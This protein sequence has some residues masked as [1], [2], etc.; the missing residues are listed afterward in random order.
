[1]RKNLWLLVVAA[2]LFIFA[3]CSDDKDDKDIAGEIAG[4][5]AGTITVTQED[6][7]K[8]GDPMENQKIY[9]TRKGNN[10]VDLELKD[11]QF[12]DVPVGALTVPAVE[13]A[14]NGLVAGNASQVSVMGGAIKA[15]LKV[16]GT[17]KDNKADLLII[18]EAPLVPGGESIKMN[19]TFKGTK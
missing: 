5:Y 17:I 18:V 3:A 12:G 4:T 15:G 14:D 10:Q 6:G 9:I 8:M 13:V 19:V 2:L 16:S 7:S 11:F 1:M